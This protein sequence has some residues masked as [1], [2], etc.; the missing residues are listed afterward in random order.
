M[1]V[2]Y[3]SDVVLAPSF[4]TCRLTEPGPRM[5]LGRFLLAIFRRLSRSAYA[6]FF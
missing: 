6:K 1:A 4:L 5:G 3:V 2:R